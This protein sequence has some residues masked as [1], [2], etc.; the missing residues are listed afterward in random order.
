MTIVEC[1]QEYCKYR[2][3]KGICK[4]K[5]VSVKAKSKM[6]RRPYSPNYGGVALFWAVCDSVE[7]K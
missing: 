3:K 7:A 1:S 2:S 5:K 6:D 4:K